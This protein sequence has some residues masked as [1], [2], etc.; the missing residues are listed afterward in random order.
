M[1][2]GVRFKGT[3]RAELAC[4]MCDN[5]MDSGVMQVVMSEIMHM[6]CSYTCMWANAA[7]FTLILHRKQ[8]N[9]DCIWHGLNDNIVDI[10]CEMVLRMWTVY[11]QDINDGFNDVCKPRRRLT[12]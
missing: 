9:E 8:K 3:S 1:A 11:K 2:W 6:H 10:I 5:A 12:V 4:R 7:E